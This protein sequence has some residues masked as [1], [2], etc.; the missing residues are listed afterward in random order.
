VD[1]ALSRFEW[2]VGDPRWAGRIALPPEVVPGWMEEVWSLRRLVIASNRRDPDFRLGAGC[3][4]E[5][6]PQDLRA[7]HLLARRGGRMAGCVRVLLPAAGEPGLAE[8]LLGPERYARVLAA[9]GVRRDVSAE[10]GGWLTHPDFRD[11][12]LLGLLTAGACA[13]AG[14][15]GADAV[16]V[17]VGACGGEGRAL[18]RLGL[19]HAPGADP[20]FSPEANDLV[21]LMYAR[22]P[23]P[24]A[25]DMACELA[26]LLALLD[27][28]RPTTAPGPR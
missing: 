14:A 3:R 2:Q 16:V 21:R 28:L 9:L 20:V 27:R 7:C 1:Q 12:R 13:L 11:G 23:G 25:S 4:A 18:T 24:A 6:D 5:R 8:S 10:V 26:D 22:P 15:L 17:P 19:R